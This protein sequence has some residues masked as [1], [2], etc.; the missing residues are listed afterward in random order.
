MV[1]G[2]AMLMAAGPYG[3]WPQYFP[4]S[5]PMLVIARR[6]PEIAIVLWICGIAG[7][8]TGAAGC[9]NFCKREVS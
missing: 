8:V 9:M 4:W 7:I 6:P 3:A 5:L 1:T 2:F